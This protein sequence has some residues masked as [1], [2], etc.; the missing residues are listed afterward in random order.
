MRGRPLTAVGLLALAVANA[1]LVAVIAGQFLAGGADVVSTPER[2]P[3][4]SMS[5]D[6][7][8]NARAIGDYVQTLAHPVFFKSR[9]PFVAPPPAPPVVAKPPPPPVITDPGLALAGVMIGDG[10]RK[11][12]LVGKADA[13]GTW[14]S[15]GDDVSGWKIRSVDAG[16]VKLQQQDRTIELLLYPRQ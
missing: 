14:A 10:Q 7:A 13:R 4:L 1:S 6:G 15:E 3:K 8:A 11:A 16:T 12:Y 5:S 9:E 2:L